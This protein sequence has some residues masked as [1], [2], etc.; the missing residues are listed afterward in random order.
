[1]I[2]EMNSCPF[3]RMR[4]INV[5]RRDFVQRSMIMHFSSNKDATKRN[6]YHDDIQTRL[7]RNVFHVQLQ[8]NASE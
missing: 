5:S 8:Q 1:M 6:K 2:A 3:L 4:I 7:N